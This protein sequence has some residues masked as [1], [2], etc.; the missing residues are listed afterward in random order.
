[1][2]A[3]DAMNIALAI[4]R[5]SGLWLVDRRGDRGGPFAG[6]WEFPGGK[7]QAGETPEVAA[8]RECAEET[9]LQVE[10]AGRLELV[11]HDYDRLRV[12]LHPVLCRAVSGTA[13]PRDRSVVEVGWVDD[14]TL[15]SLEMPA[16]NRSVIAE[17]LGRH[18][19]DVGM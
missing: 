10:P 4:V 13:F 19:S 7:I 14:G 11:E 17:L 5:Q 12:R 1:M 18:S 6:L 15:A 16:A 2:S 3:V 9:S 8:V